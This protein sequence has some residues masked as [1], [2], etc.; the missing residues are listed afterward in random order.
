MKKQNLCGKSTLK[1]FL[2]CAGVLGSQD[3]YSLGSC[4]L[5]VKDTVTICLKEKKPSFEFKPEKVFMNPQRYDFRRKYIRPIRDFHK[6]DLEEEK[7]LKRIIEKLNR[8]RAI[9]KEL[10]PRIESGIL[11]VTC[12]GCGHKQQIE[13]IQPFNCQDFKCQGC[14]CKIRINF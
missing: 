8:D 12:N 9:K 7:E 13:L 10:K 11:V 4:F 3:P 5:G 1:T 2:G 14:G 6:K